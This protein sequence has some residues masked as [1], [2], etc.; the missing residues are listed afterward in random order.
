MLISTDKSYKINPLFGS[1][2]CLFGA[3]KI[4]K[5]EQ[6]TMAVLRSHLSLFL[7]PLYRSSLFSCIKANIVKD[8]VVL[9]LLR[10]FRNTSKN[11]IFYC[12][13]LFQTMV[14]SLARSYS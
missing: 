3:P 13:F 4:R 12:P 7:R 1:K 2:F 8:G 11:R 6:G 10:F 5:G 9:L 14:V